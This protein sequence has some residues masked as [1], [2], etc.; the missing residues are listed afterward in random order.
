MENLSGRLPGRYR[1]AV[2][3][4]LVFAFATAAAV[5]ATPHAMS[6]LCSYSLD[7]LV[8]TPARGSARSCWQLYNTV[9]TVLGVSK[10]CHTKYNLRACDLLEVVDGRLPP[11]HLCG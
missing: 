3:V 5:G 9:S 2:I 6:P 10:R 1:K 4:L 7:F 11:S 8:F